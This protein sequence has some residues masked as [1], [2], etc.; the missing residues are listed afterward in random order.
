MR[1]KEARINEVRV[2]TIIAKTATLY[3]IP[4][5]LSDRSKGGGA[6]VGPVPALLCPGR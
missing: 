1:I 6:L 3:D 4:M 5:P 2:Y